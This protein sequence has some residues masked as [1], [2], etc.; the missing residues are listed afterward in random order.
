MRNLANDS[1][2][3]TFCFF[4]YLVGHP[5]GPGAIADGKFEGMDMAE[6]MS[7]AMVQVSWKSAGIHPE[8][9]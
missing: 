6:P 4:T 3:C 7:R 2:A 8:N 1:A 9:R 5:G